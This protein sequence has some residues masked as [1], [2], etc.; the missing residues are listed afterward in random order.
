MF[1]EARDCRV[2]ISDSLVADWTEMRFDLLMLRP[3]KKKWPYKNGHIK[4]VELLK[5][6]IIFYLAV[7]GQIKNGCNVQM[8]IT[9]SICPFSAK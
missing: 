5:L 1:L 3:H 2:S 7:F 4:E 8:Q 6:A 9:K